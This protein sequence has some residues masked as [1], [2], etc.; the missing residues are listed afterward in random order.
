MSVEDKVK[1]IIA[2]T[3]SI[4]L[5]EVMPESSFTADLNADSLDFIE[6]VMLLEDEFNMKI[7]DEDAIKM[8]IVKDVI[9][10]IELR[11]FDIGDTITP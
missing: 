6:I 7:V 5:N 10:F 9:E 3:L 11:G 8:L 4:N 1:K 2:E